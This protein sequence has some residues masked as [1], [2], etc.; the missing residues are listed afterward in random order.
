MTRS[1]IALL[2]VAVLSGCA[3]KAPAPTPVPAPDVPVDAPAVYSLDIR[4]ENDSDGKLR[5]LLQQNLDI[6][7]YRASE[8]ALSRVELARLA[9]AAPAQAATLLETEGYFNASADVAREAGDETRVR[10]LVKPG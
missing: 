2:L 7:R 8:A 6:A 4:V 5:G 9:A 1:V 10:L 3:T